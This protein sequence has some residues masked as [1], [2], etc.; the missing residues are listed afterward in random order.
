VDRKDYRNRTITEA[1]SGKTEF[2]QAPKTIKLADGTERP[3]EEL[4]PE[5]VG[6]LLSSVE[7]ED[8]S[9]LGPHGWP[10][11]SWPS[12]TEILGSAKA[13]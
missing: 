6:K 5:E 1:L 12:W 10:S 7:P 8:V 9:W 3:I 13:P 2:Y 11:E 4:Q